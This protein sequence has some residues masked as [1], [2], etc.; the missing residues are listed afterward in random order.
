[1]E[2]T[3]N[4][5]RYE[6]VAGQ[7]PSLQGY[8]QFS[9][10][11]PLQNTSAHDRETVTKLATDTSITLT[12]IFPWL[13]GQVVNEGSGPDNS[14]TFKIISYRGVEAGF[15]IVVRYYPELDYNMIMKRK[16]PMDELDGELFSPKQDLSALY[17]LA[18]TPE[19]VMVLQLNYLKGGVVLTFAAAHNAM[20]MNGLGKFI[21]FFGKVSKGESL[22][23]EEMGW[24]NSDRT[25]IV[26]LL[27]PGEVELDHSMFVAE[28]ENK[29]RELK[30][31]GHAPAKARW[32]YVRFTKE[33][34]ARMK[35]MA[36]PRHSQ[37]SSDRGGSLNEWIST[38]DAISSFIWQHITLARL[39]RLSQKTSSSST[40][41]RA[42]NG[43][44]L[45]EPP[46][47]SSYMGHMI[48]STWNSVSLPDFTTLALPE[49]AS[50]LRKE[51]NRMNDYSIRS[52]LTFIHRHKN[53]RPINY[54][55]GLELASQDL[56]LSSGA[57]LVVYHVDFGYPLGMPECVR[58]PQWSSVEG[59]VYLMPK[60][61]NGDLDAAICLG[62]DDWMKLKEDQ[63]WNEFG[64]YIG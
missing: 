63:I 15:D 61:R 17:D 60:M 46:I 51:L 50:A 62:E 22:T 7:L 6:D 48:F 32:A 47:S 5:S 18:R 30:N 58:R 33:K 3:I 44:R 53:K 20:D 37:M 36:A 56:L 41:R 34:L 23:K 10:F 40:F 54:A 55:S 49:I 57:G 11:F 38:D 52:F 2:D 8:T 59:V 64:E 42:V 14:G 27:G 12:S 26:K 43:R 39:P 21:E 1:M 13:S 16:A 24:G 45:L 31:D 25:N 4:W 9:L 19:P 35:E 29:R 28:P